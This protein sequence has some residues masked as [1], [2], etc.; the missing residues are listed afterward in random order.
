MG[1]SLIRSFDFF[2]RTE[3]EDLS[4]SSMLLQVDV[5]KIEEVL[6]ILEKIK[7]AHGHLDILVNN[8]ATFIYE[9]IQDVTEA[10]KVCMWSHVTTLWEPFLLITR[11]FFTM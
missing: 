6:P 8:A 3:R 4:Q 2:P 10:G 7:E 11:H 5:S 1:Q 9:A